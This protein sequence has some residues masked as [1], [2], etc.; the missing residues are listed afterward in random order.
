MTVMDVL[1]ADDL[2]QL[3]ETLRQSAEQFYDET[4][5]ILTD[6]GRQRVHFGESSDSVHPP[7]AI[8]RRGVDKA[9]EVVLFPKNLQL[10]K[11]M[12]HRVVFAI[13]RDAENGTVA[14]TKREVRFTSAGPEQ[15]VGPMDI[16]KEDYIVL[17]MI[18]AAVASRQSELSLA[19]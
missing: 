15:D 5:T 2:T 14:L 1:T 17:D 11:E 13:G 19:S 18:F 9:T 6:E 16:T 8:L 4:Q 12:G 10:I 3:D 7:S